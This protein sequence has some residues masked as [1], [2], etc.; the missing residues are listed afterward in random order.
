ML[1]REIGVKARL[2]VFT[3]AA[4]FLLMVLTVAKTLKEIAD[5]IVPVP[6]LD[7]WVTV[8]RRLNNHGLDFSNIFSQHNEHRIPL[9]LLIDLLDMQF[10]GGQGFLEL[11]ITTFS[12][13]VASWAIWMGAVQAMIRFS[14]EQI[15]CMLIMLSLF[16]C[17]SQVEVWFWPFLVGNV[18][19]NTFVIV[20][21]CLLPYAISLQSTF[22][23]IVAIISS[24]LAVFGLAS[25]VLVWPLGCLIILFLE[26]RPTLNLILWCLAGALVLG[27]YF[28]GFVRPS[29]HANPVDSVLH[30][31]KDVLYFVVFLMGAPIGFFGKMAAVF[32]GAAI[33][34]LGLYAISSTIWAVVTKS[35]PPSPGT[36][37]MTAVLLFSFGCALAVAGSRLNFGLDHASSSRYTTIP[38]IALA[39][40]Y[41]YGFI[42]CKHRLTVYHAGWSVLLMLLFLSYPCDIGIL[43]AVSGTLKTA[44]IALVLNINDQDVF[45]RITPAS[46]R[47]PE[48]RQYLEKRNLS[49]FRGN[50][51]PVGILLS[52]IGHEAYPLAC[53]GGIEKSEP[54]STDSD[55]IRL[56]GWARMDAPPHIP[57][58]IAFVEK[59]TGMVIGW[60]EPGGASAPIEGLMEG[61]VNPKRWVGYA[62][63]TNADTVR[64]YALSSKS[65]EFC[66][67]Q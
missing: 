45:A 43:R 46:E 29:Y 8:F 34:G 30:N 53:S 28:H 41:G 32:L 57:E 12:M 50:Q 11:I 31:P 44:G 20:A 13:I 39:A 55:A 16:F 36:I 62:K 5:L 67:L 33:L 56:T 35:I 51:Y 4:L 65:K 52:D 64:V 22:L 15:S 54:I 27:L 23:F 61:T 58:H 47:V 66:L 6:W 7:Q 26:R 63:T 14:L 10:L 1:F 42:R 24:G 18:L 21:L 19:S 49:V 59:A 40:L 25:G 9:T 48:A 60:A 38:I 2:L 37:A 3:T 17:V